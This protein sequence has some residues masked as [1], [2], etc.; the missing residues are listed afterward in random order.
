MGSINIGYLGVEISEN[1]L[2]SDITIG[3]GCSACESGQPSLVDVSQ[4]DFQ[5]SVQDDPLDAPT[6]AADPTTF[7]NYLTH[8]FWQDTGR[9]NRSWTQDN[10]TFSLSNEFTA[11]QKAGIRMAFDLWADVADISFT[12]VGSGANITILEGDD[13]RAYSSSTTSGTTIISNIISMDT[14]VS[15]WSNFNDLGDYALMTALH[16]IGHSLGLG[17]TGNYNGT[18]SYANDA[19]WTNDTH[20][21]TVMSYFNDT[22]V[23]SDHWNSSGVWQYSATPMLIDIVAI[24]SIYGADYT[25][26]SGNTTYGFNSNAG[27][28]QYDFSIADVPI[29]IWDGGG[30]D[31]IDLSGYSQNNTLYLTEGDFSSVGYMTNNLVIAY[32]AVIENA[33]GGS[34]NDTIYGNDADN[35]ILG[36]NGND[37]IHGSLGNDSLDGEGGTDTLVYNYSVTEF[38]FNFINNIAVSINHIAQGFTDLVSNFENFIFTDGSYTFAELESNF[39][40]LETI[41]IRSY[42]SGGGTYGYNSEANGD[43]TITASD[44]GY[45]GSSG[46][47]YTVSRTGYDTTITINDSNAAPTMRVYGTDNADTVTIN[48]THSAMT[49]QLYTYAGSDTI[50]ILVS[51]NDRIDSGSGDDVVNSGDGADKVYGREGNDTL[52][53]EDGNDRLY[54]MDDDDILNG[55]LGNDLLDGGNG[56]DTLNGGE[57]NDRL[58]G[59]E[60]NDI[61]NGGEGDDR[62]DAEGGNDTLNGGDGFD[63]LYGYDGQDTLNGGN[64]NDRLY[65]MNDNDILNGDDGHDVLEGGDGDDVLNGGEGN[66]RLIGGNNN[67]TLSGDNGHDTLY[68]QNGNDIMNGGA[69]NDELF[70]GIGNDTMTGGSGFNTFYGQG[71]SDIFGFTNFDTQLDQLLDFTLTG[72]EADSIN[73]TDILS[74][75][76]QGTSDINDFVTLSYKHAD[77]TDLFI[78]QDGV[79]SDWALVGTIRG[80]DFAGTSVDDLVLSGQ[81]ITNVSLL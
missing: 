81:L 57:G 59:G 12:E 10:I 6:S 80:S 58:I 68:G 24:Q 60:G 34:G 1:S 35:Y 73:I 14:N 76:N 30:T 55:G 29:A 13:S 40:S 44:M 64:N 54:G 49:A 2:N 22:N 69:G 27:R 36:G 52:N 47:Q 43:T 75:F 16:E 78:N 32:G 38:A 8:G 3:C 63:K 42:W 41:A 19:Q 67:D 74:G 5:N 61:L 62:I 20:Q 25:T 70:G 31:T 65:G 18:A 72:A 4:A 56:V 37:T 71:G 15:G 77:R 46:N 51:G 66:D 48:G 11:D 9:S 79:G 7:A 28:D 53:G 21:M 33:V 39:G 23:G 45:T 50:D 17:H 26:R